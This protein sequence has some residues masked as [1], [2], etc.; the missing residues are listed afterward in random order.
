MSL[1]NRNEQIIEWLNLFLKKKD[2]INFSGLI[3]LPVEASNR[4]YYRFKINNKKFILMDA[5]P[6]KASKRQTENFIYI[7]KLFKEYGLNTPIVYFKNLEKGFLIISDLGILTYYDYI[8]LNKNNYNFNIS[9]LYKTAINSL[10]KIQVNTKENILEEY[11]YDFQIKYMNYFVDI[12]LK[13]YSNKSIDNLNLL[14]TFEIIMNN[15][16]NQQ[17]VF[18][19]ID[20]HSRN[21]IYNTKNNNLNPGII[22]F[23]HAKMGPICY[24]LASLLH[25]SYIDLDENIIEELLYYYWE[26]A[27]KININTDY[28]IFYKDFEYASLQ[29]CI[30]NIGIF[31][32]LYYESNN[33]K[34]I[35][36]IPKLIKR[37]KLICLKYIELNNL[38]KILLELS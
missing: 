11:N 29:R 28:N 20:Y 2:S 25:D 22:D 12:Y 19:H 9:E 35:I 33:D 7:S 4:I 5:N 6:E 23:Q 16:N 27:K 38:Y 3:K 26:N 34:F 10:L 14:D 15:L 32:K 24:D 21:L 31:S 13:K 36:Y 1:D 30:K 18:I 8:T 37:C 17:K